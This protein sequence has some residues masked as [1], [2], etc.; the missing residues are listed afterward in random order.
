MSS[1]FFLPKPAVLASG[2]FSAL[3][4][5]SA[6]AATFVVD[7][8]SDTSLSTCDINTVNDCSLRGAITAANLTTLVDQIHFDIPQSDVG[9]QS[10]TQH[11]RISVGSTSLPSISEGVLIDGFTQAGAVANTNTPAQGG[12]NSV[13][14]IEIIPGSTFGNQQNGID[15]FSNNF[16]A[17]AST[18]RGLAISRFSSQIVLGGNSAHRVEGCYLGTDITGTVS[19]VNTPSGRG[20]GVRLQSQ[21]AYQIGGTMPAQRNLLSG[22]SDAVV[23]QSLPDGLVIAGNLF[24]TN[25]A[26]TQAIPNTSI[27]LNFIQGGLRNARIGGTDPLARNVISASGFW[28]ILLSAQGATPFLGTRIEGNYFGTDWTG[29]R[30]LGNGLNPNSPSQV[31]SAIKIGGIVACDLVIGG[32]N[33]GQANLIAYSGKQGVEN[34]QCRGVQASDN[35]FIGNRDVAFDNV[36]GGGAI[37]LTPNDPGDADDNLGNRGQN[38]PELTLGNPNLALVQYRVDTAVA[39]ASY[40]ITVNFYRAACGGGA[41]QRVASANISAAQAQQNLTIDL[42]ATSFL[43]LTAVAVDALGNQSEFAPAIGDAIFR[44]DFEDVT[45]P[46]TVGRCF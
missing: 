28:A 15:T 34:D 26:G 30:A 25:A 17:A 38:Y 6:Q 22:L 4:F 13:L 31:T 29:T 45:A 37:G 43:P 23:Q 9:F 7:T 33:P 41:A 39:N 18:I 42:S 44:S 8:T 16:S 1:N 14:K 24:G 2:L 19:A 27:A 40:P 11:W 3:C 36:V 46:L 5:S 32:A 21:G 12:L 20:A 35:V 10:A